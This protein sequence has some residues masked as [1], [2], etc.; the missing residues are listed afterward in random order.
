MSFSFLCF[1]FTAFSVQF[2]LLFHI[3]PSV[4]FIDRFLKMNVFKA[5]FLCIFKYQSL[6]Q[7]NPDLIS[8]T[9]NNLTSV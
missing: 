8:M 4:D 3:N 6:V 7:V 5:V 2:F 9:Y 1:L